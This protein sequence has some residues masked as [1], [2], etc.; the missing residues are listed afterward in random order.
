MPTVSSPDPAISNNAQSKDSTIDAIYAAGHWLLSRHRIA[1]A[2][3]A[4]RV[5]LRASPRDERAWLG[6][7]QCHER[8]SQPLIALELYGTG[9]VVARQGHAPSVRCLLA[10][11]RALTKMGLDAESVLDA[12]DEAAE[13]IGSE[14]LLVLV[15]RERGRFS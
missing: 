14:E 5:M 15:G 7:G 1:E 8:I 9:A 4:F 10:R 11:A 13:R 3:A 12:A 6:L 2:A